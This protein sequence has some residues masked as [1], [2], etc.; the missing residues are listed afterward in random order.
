MDRSEGIPG[1]GTLPTVE[2][3]LA[4]YWADAEKEQKQ[5]RRSAGPVEAVERRTDRERSAR[6]SA[7]EQPRREIRKRSTAGAEGPA[8]SPKRQKEKG[9]EPDPLVPVKEWG[10]DLEKRFDA[11]VRRP[12]QSKKRAET[13]REERRRE[14]PAAPSPVKPEKP[15][16]ERRPAPEEAPPATFSVDEILAEFTGGTP[17]RPKPPAETEKQEIENSSMP[18]DVFFVPGHGEEEAE[19][20]APQ[21]KMPSPSQSRESRVARMAREARQT[22]KDLEKAPAARE[23][24]PRAESGIDWNVE[25]DPLP[26]DPSPLPREEEIDPRFALDGQASRR[27]RYDG[28]DL[29]LSPE[30]GYIPPQAKEEVPFHWS[31]EPEEAEEKETDPGF[32][33]RLLSSRKK[34]AAKADRAPEE[35]EERYETEDTPP[36]PPVPEEP[37]EESIEDSSRGYAPKREYA[38]QVELPPEEGEDFPSFGQ[39]LSGQLSSLLLRARGLGGNS[40]ATDEAD[41][42]DLGRELSPGEA[43]RYYAGF[44]RFQRLRLRIGLALLAVM[45][46]IGF[47][48]PVTG[49]LR[50]A[51]VSAA[52]LL[53][54]QLCV[55]L[56]CLDIVTN[57]AVNLT[58]LRFGADSLAVLCC[59]LTSFDALAV[60]AGA[61]GTPH[62]PL[63]FFSSAALL[64]VLLSSLL[65]SRSL[66]KVFRVPEIDYRNA[67]TGEADLTGD[68]LTLMKS[69]RPLKGFVRRAEEMPPDESLFLRLS[70]LLAALALLMA[71]IVVGVKKSFS[72]FLY[73]YTALLCPALPLGALLCFALPFFFGTYRIFGKGAAIAGWSGLCDIGKSRNLIVTDRDLFPEGT[74]KM[75]LMR[76][77]AGTR[78]ERV[79]T[80][81]GSMVAASGIGFGVCFAEQMEEFHCKPLPVENFEF[82]PGGGLRGIIDGHVILCGG[83]ELMRLMNVRLHPK[84]GESTNVLLSV[85]GELQGI[86]E[87]HYEPK[88]SVR[89]ALVGLIRSTRHPIFALRDFL[90]T[91][92]M[93][94]KC[95]DVSTD[96]YDFPPYVDRQALSEARPDKRSKIAGVLGREGLEP[97]V[98]LADTGRAVY[99]AVRLNLA[100]TLAA[101]IAGLLLSFSKLLGAGALGLGFLLL[102]ALLPALAVLLISIFLQR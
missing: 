67:V 96:G 59:L 54:L 83:I 13:P 87:L 41:E 86:F 2:E 94:R 55:M 21:E 50:A 26:R 58:R 43:K 101:S 66:R 40:I 48:L 35:D 65:S 90:V 27:M 73:V 24:A 89:K 29:D 3:I 93:L 16:R 56:L 30:E 102:L 47:G 61:F 63:C 12:P 72:D 1:Q 84:L 85:D 20:A 100:V 36:A 34:P 98:C 57:C 92:S 25:A 8:R 7:P 23:A 68:E 46:W 33:Q 64:A 42:E 38:E 81:A 37:A 95:F 5:E 91:P 53:G 60:A 31:R 49:A 39:Y 99:T 22:V 4:E 75:G 10:K 80:Y 77:L 79:L 18:N 9:T 52:V 17:V 78:P 44:I 70:P 62:T 71:L 32:F 45:A 97:M 14:A 51:P 11:L 15:L 74:I 69:P 19:A 28:R 88:D 6:R 76:S 82:L